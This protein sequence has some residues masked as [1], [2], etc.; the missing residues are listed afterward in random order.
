MYKRINRFS[1]WLSMLLV[2]A[3]V[4]T[5]APVSAAP[6]KQSPQL[7]DSTTSYEFRACQR[8]ADK[9]A[10]RN[11]IANL[12]RQ[13]LENPEKPLDFTAIVEEKWEQLAVDA[14]ID[15]VVDEVIDQIRKTT[16]W[17]EI[18]KSSWSPKEAEEI[19]KRATEQVFSSPRITTKLED[20]SMGVAEEISQHITAQFER[21]ATVGLRCLEE[22]AGHNYSKELYDQLLE[23][24]LNG[25]Q[26]KP[27]VPPIRITPRDASEKVIPGLTVLLISSLA[28]RLTK[29][30]G[31]KL[32][33]R[34][35]GKIITRI[36]GKGVSSLVPIV[37][38][39]IGLGMLV[40]DL[41]RMFDGAFP[42]I[43][44][45]LKDPEV[46]TQIKSEIVKAIEEN[47]PDQV[48]SVAL[49]IA[50]RLVDQWDSF[51][52]NYAGICRLM[53]TNPTFAGIV[54]NATLVELDSLRQLIE[55]YRR[56]LGEKELLTSIDNGDF[57]KVLQALYSF[58][59]SQEGVPEGFRSKPLN[60]PLIR[61]LKDTRN[62]ADAL[63][64]AELAN[65]KIKRLLDYAVHY[66]TSLDEW[67]RES[68]IAVLS[69]PK[70]QDIEKLLS[71]PTEKRSVL[72]ALPPEQMKAL[73]ARCS[74]S[75][76][77][78]LTTQM[79]T[80]GTPPERI[81]EEAADD[82]LW[83]NSQ[84]MTLASPSTTPSTKSSPNPTPSPIPPPPTAPFNPWSLP[85]QWPILAFVLAGLALEV[86]FVGRKLALHD[87]KGRRIDQDDEDKTNP[88]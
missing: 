41:W 51:C 73:V 38:W 76:L 70:G 10:L 72:T 48:D 59:R 32:M 22:Y 88:E 82:C 26:P 19:L 74:E 25:V 23:D 55:F 81:A 34:I 65:G 56:E 84:M 62:T 53:E 46:K 18:L 42:Q 14:T 87:R 16:D 66:S 39:V 15:S 45:A 11:E 54:K 50:V 68:L 75:Q 58:V 64:W 2:V 6:P 12:V 9:Q 85:N 52:L 37:G 69:L 44:E 60:A 21:A 47:L 24:I 83:E 7:H 35:G 57:Q 4:L 63:R 79:L 36:L 49:E 8:A 77:S 71:L 5:S 27:T 33:E 31:Q 3:L 78:E 29:E 86:A 43:K 1:R 67:N 61:L 20:L 30:I 28:P 13:A 80:S 17:V 40:H